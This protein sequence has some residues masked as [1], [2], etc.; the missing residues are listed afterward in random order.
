MKTYYIHCGNYRKFEVDA[1]NKEIAVERFKQAK[2][3][4][5][6]KEDITGIELKD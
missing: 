6:S 5:F 2:P 3:S 1:D 4:G